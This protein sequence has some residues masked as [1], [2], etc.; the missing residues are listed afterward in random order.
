MKAQQPITNTQHPTIID[1]LCDRAEMTPDRLA[2]IG[3]Q[4]GERAEL[5]LTYGELERQARAI[6]AGLSSQMKVGERIL[7]IYPYDAGLAFIAAFLGCLYAGIVAV[8]CHPPRN[9]HGIAEILGR[10]ESA[11]TRAILAPKSL[12]A[13]LKR[14]FQ[15]VDAPVCQWLTLTETTKTVSSDWQRPDVRAETLAFLQYTSGSTGIPKGVRI[16]HKSLFHNQKRLASAFGHNEDSVGVGWLPLFH[17]MGLIGNVLQAIYLGASCVLMSPIAFIQKPVRW[18]QAISHYRA[19][20]SGGPNFAYDL[21]CDRVSEEELSRLDLSSW[22]VAF[23]GAEPVRAETLARFASKFAPCGFRSEAFYPCYGMAEATLFIAGGQ[24]LTPPAIANVEEAALSENRVVSVA[25]NHSSQST[26]VSC[27]RA[28]FDD[29]IAIADPQ[30]YHLCPPDRVGEIWVC[31][32]GLGKGYW[33]QPKESDRTFGAYLADTGEGPFLRTGDLGFIKEGELFITGRLNDVLVF[34]G[35]N[36]YPEQIERVV[37]TCHPAFLP[38]SSAAFAVKI[39]GRDLL[40]I[41]QEVERQQ[42]DR[43]TA[44]SVAESI[45][46]ALFDQYFLDVYA[47]ALLKPKGIPRTSSG[48]IQRHACREQYV[49]GELG[50]LDEWRSPK[51]LDMPALISRYLNPI[52]HFRRWWYSIIKG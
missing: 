37:A 16:T 5:R 26:L 23:S 38:N 42:R 12:Q 28:W 14:Q 31:G 48:K 24:K 9:R 47:I 46:W 49:R 33:N 39:E 52:V 6:A 18:L 1:L 7:L 2:F 8:P 40:V 11:Q 50:I 30:T 15:K 22:E 32:A 20:T 4:D 19:T 13:K 3:L 34:W 44:Q 17:D 36:H 10:L 35:L 25:E 43:L 41:V 27:G 21:L 45:R 51:T 29:R